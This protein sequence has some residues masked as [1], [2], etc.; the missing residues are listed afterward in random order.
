MTGPMTTTAIQHAA[1]DWLLR[2]ING[3]DAEGIEARDRWL[4][5]HPD[6]RSI[7][8][9]LKRAWGA[10]DAVA[11]DPQI[12]A[13]R[14]EALRPSRWS[15]RWWSL[16]LAASLVAGLTGW[17]GWSQREAPPMVYETGHAQ[18]RD[19]ALSDGS[20][21]LLD[22]ESRVSVRMGKDLRAI[23]LDRGQAYFTVAHAPQRPFVVTAGTRAIEA[24]G[25]QFDVKRAAGRM[26]VALTQGRVRVGPADTAPDDLR[27][28][29]PGRGDELSAGQRLTFDTGTGV[30]TIAP[31]GALAASDWRQ[32]RLH[33]DRTPLADVLADFNRHIPVPIRLADPQLGRL[34]ISG[35]FSSDNA[36]G[37]L[38]A[39]PLLFPL[40]VD[41]HRDVVILSAP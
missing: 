4:A 22:A 35:I 40:R 3:L 25:T 36:E 27:P 23:S 12:L 2:E 30:S 39:L 17:W 15:G 14:E 10:L 16:G 33:F 29:S 19:L 1:A 32:G 21:I 38:R 24:L 11:D 28:G 37:F 6:H 8:A 18:T 20:H 26:T 9:G 5:E 31:D 34:P 41:H 13:L 7:H